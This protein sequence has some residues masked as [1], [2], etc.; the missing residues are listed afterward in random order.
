M[1]DLR[2][3]QQC[4]LRGFAGLQK[5]AQPMSRIHTLHLAATSAPNEAE[6]DASDSD[7]TGV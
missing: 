5:W 6:E 1:I 7:L 4:A 2:N 3:K